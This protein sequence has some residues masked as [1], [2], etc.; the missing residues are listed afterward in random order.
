MEVTVVLAGLAV[1]F[2]IW[3]L[4]PLLPS[5]RRRRVRNALYGRHVWITGGSQGL[6]FSIA[7]F[8]FRAGAR[9]TISSRSSR[10]LA[11]AAG[12]IDS[13]VRHVVAD[14]GGRGAALRAAFASVEAGH[15]PVDIVVANAGV[16]HG[17]RPFVDLA[18]EEIES[19]IATN[20]LGVARTFACVI[21]G[22]LRRGD[23]VLCAVSSLAAY[24][25][26]PG[27]SVYGASKAGVTA[28]CQSLAV[29][30]V[31]TGIA[32]S[33]A[34]PGFVDTPAITDLDHPKPFQM[35]A[36]HAAELVLD[37]IARRVNHVGFPWLMENV[38]TRFSRALPC[39]L[40]NWILHYTADH[41]SHQ[42]VADLG[43]SKGR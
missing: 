11:D 19:I 24:R 20:L 27:A 34:H 33:C 41:R 30:L 43:E 5:L 23:G 13:S 8:A 21:P 2:V 3:A 42:A 12:A 32:V 39:F 35:S 37:G 25:G 29:E 15:G 1:A 22:M 9:V 38:V 36:D 31:G 7:L 17:G 26:V 18:D 14:V 16:N 40:Y 6:G 28:V 10:R 4:V